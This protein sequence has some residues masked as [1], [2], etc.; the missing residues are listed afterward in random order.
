MEKKTQQQLDS[1]KISVV[2]ASVLIFLVSDNLI[3]TGYFD[4]GLDLSLFGLI[5]PVDLGFLYSAMISILVIV[6]ML[7]ILSDHPGQ[8]IRKTQHVFLPAL[9]VFILSVALKQLPLGATFWVILA[10]GGGLLYLTLVSEYISADTLDMR[11]PIASSGLQTL[12]YIIFFIFISTLSYGNQR[13]IFQVI[14]I[15]IASFAIAERNFFLRTGRWKNLWSLTIGFI[16]TQIMVGLHY[17]PLRPY[18]FGVISAGVLFALIEL[19]QDIEG[20]VDRIT[21]IVPGL[22]LFIF[23]LIGFI[24]T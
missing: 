8:S 22:I 17:L 16:V 18:Q 12:A 2:L 3:P 21:F 9:F 6:G 14:F 10:V 1:N 13:L 11:Y 20:E 23:I 15:F 4:P 19:T 7:W 24:F 5:I